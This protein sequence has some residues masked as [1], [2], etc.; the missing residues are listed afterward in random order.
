[1]AQPVY[2][3]LLV[4]DNPGPSH[5]DGTCKGWANVGAISSGDHGKKCRIQGMFRLLESF[6]IGVCFD[7]VF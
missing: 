3:P 7:F 2:I 1:M 6:F 5:V 4:L